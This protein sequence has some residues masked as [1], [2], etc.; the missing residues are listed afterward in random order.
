MISEATEAVCANEST[1]HLWKQ[2]RWI[3][4]RPEG[5]FALSNP[6][7]ACGSSFVDDFWGHR[8]CLRCRIHVSPVA[9]FRWW[10]LSRLRLSFCWCFEA[11]G[12]V[13]AVESTSHPWKPFYLLFLS[14]YGLFALSNLGITPGST[15]VD[16]FWV[17]S[18]CLRSRIHKSPVEAL[19]LNISE[20]LRAVCAVES[21]RHLWK[22][23]RR[24]F[25]RPHGLF[26]LSNPCVSRG[27][28]FVD[29]F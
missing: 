12:A 20:S 19:S 10:F 4:L 16:D 1:R 9:A 3:F 26:A 21:M 29:D 18:G 17:P 7:V 14:H 23:F 13:C 15:F 25:L 11:T 22:Q 24:R 5:L 8:G 28:I 27:S 6:C 2:F